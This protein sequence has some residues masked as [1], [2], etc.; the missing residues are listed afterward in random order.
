MSGQAQLQI[1][2]KRLCEDPI[3]HT[4]AALNGPLMYGFTFCTVWWATVFNTKLVN[5]V[6]TL[7]NDSVYWLKR[8]S[9]FESP[10]VELT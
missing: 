5:C 2:C 8:G 7:A 4:W 1:E 9:K 6:S 3:H 10:F